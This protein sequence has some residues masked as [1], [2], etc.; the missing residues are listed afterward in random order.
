MYRKQYQN[1]V[2]LVTFYEVCKICS[3]TKKQMGKKVKHSLKK[4][5]KPECTVSWYQPMDIS[6]REAL[7]TWMSRFKP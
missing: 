6:V 7:P 1:I 2:N 4:L 5:D 3:N